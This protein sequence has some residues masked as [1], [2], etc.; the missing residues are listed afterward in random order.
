MAGERL[1]KGYLWR[2]S[3]IGLLP[4]LATKLCLGVLAPSQLSCS[5]QLA[6]APEGS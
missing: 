4:N 5:E 2:A 3:T 1:S 6:A